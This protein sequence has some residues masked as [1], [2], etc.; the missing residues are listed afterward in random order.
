MARA[1]RW[2]AIV[3]VSGS[4]S[5][6]GQDPPPSPPTD[7][8][9]VAALEAS[10]NRVRDDAGIE[11]ATKTRVV[12]LY[13]QAIEDVKRAESWVAK[14]GDFEKGRVEAPERMEK[15][16]AELAQTPEE[17]KPDVPPDATLQVMEQRLAQVEAELK[18]GRE[19]AARLDEDRKIRG[20]RRTELPTA[21]VEA[22]QKVEAA[23][24]EL[25]VAP[26]ADEPAPV[27]AARRIAMEARR[28]AL[29]TELDCYEKELASYEARGD[30]LTARREQ[31]AREVTRL[32]GLVSGWRGLVNERRRVETEAAAKDASRA[33]REA[34][35]AHPAVKVIAD[36][37]AEWAE[38]RSE[39]RLSDRIERVSRRL[40]EAT[41][42]H[43]KWSDEF[44]SVE[45]RLAAKGLTHTMG[46]LLRQKREDLPGVRAH[47]QVLAELRVESS[48]VFVERTKAEDALTELI[49]T[50]DAIVQETL[51]DLDPALGELERQAIEAGIRESLQSRRDYIDA[52]V[53]DYDSYIR[54]LDDLEVQ[55]R[56][57]IG[58]LEDFRKF[59]DE[60]I[61]WVR[62]TSPPRLEGASDLMEAIVSITSPARWGAVAGALWIVARGQPFSGSLVVL[63]LVGLSALQPRFRKMLR[64]MGD[65]ASEP[66]AHEFP[67]TMRAIVYTVLLAAHWPLVMWIVGLA[68]T[69]HAGPPEFEGMV[70]VALRVTAG[71]FFIA[72]FVRHSCR[73]KG[74]C[75]AHFG[76]PGRS[77]RVVRR[78][79]LWLLPVGLPLV[80]IATLAETSA[81]ESWRNSLGRL[82]F[83]VA[84]VLLLV[85]AHLVLRPAARVL[86]P[87]TPGRPAAWWVK[88]RHVW[89][90]AGVTLPLLFIV[91]T[92]VGYYYTAQQ[93]T[94]VLLKSLWMLLIV[95]VFESVGI[96]WLLTSRRKLAIAQARKLRQAGDEESTASTA[97]EPAIDLSSI[98]AQTRNLLRSLGVLALIFGLWFVWHDM[99]PALGILEGVE[100]WSVTQKVEVVDQQA[101]GSATSRMV[102]RLSPITLADLL[103]ALFILVATVVAGRNVPG[104]L[105]IALLQRLP[106]SSGERYA[107]SMLVRYTITVIGLVFGFGAVGLSWSTVQWLAA[108]ITV[109]LGF[110]LQEI[111]ANFVSGLILLFERPIRI[112]DTV[113]VGGVSGEVTRIRIRATTVMDWDRKELVIP[114]KEFVTGQVINWTLSDPVQRVTIKV[115]IAYGSDTAAAEE[116]LARVAADN[117]N[118]LTDPKPRVIFM[119]FGDSA[120]N[121]ELRVFIPSIDYFLQVRHELHNAIDR[122]FRKAGIEIAFPQRDIHVRSIRAAL[123]VDDG[124]R[125]APGDP[126]AAAD[127]AET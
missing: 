100:F 25:T 37:T 9:S 85:F 50:T 121:Y 21:I 67:P 93:L 76:W 69:R 107:I 43:K 86:P 75:E 46:Q 88:L 16:R 109:G 33:R 62:S 71:A 114:N 127:R 61:L 94:D 32:E 20:Q 63:A 54:K 36:A 77:L 83:V 42:S 57:L 103:L 124:R 45:K 3:M 17:P 34:A 8:M 28:R 18:A 82:A 41:K 48:D 105:E 59:I 47:Q 123:P 11:E 30:L 2:A 13:D 29:A 90:V 108:A 115:G 49:Y 58:A 113:T 53:R 70:G 111:F 122:E 89:Y 60:R 27:T 14:A 35:R 101:D 31:A 40:D 68:L 56:L 26:T 24:S 81:D 79:L 73:V 110:G 125:S 19:T 117:E 98:S 6:V 44:D 65:A 99:L 72:S 7:E 64:S 104:L 23:T 84:Q 38:K 10:R 15:I 87:P 116:V 39:A 95:L 51:A 22:R 92:V 4:W 112:G 12:G 118:V 120:L 78:H 96:R 106:L 80:F 66:Y 91:L 102:E 1:W 126:T 97:A 52:L 5:A 74:L 55:E 119:A